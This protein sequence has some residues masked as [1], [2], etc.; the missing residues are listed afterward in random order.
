VKILSGAVF[1]VICTLMV[2]GWQQLP[3]EYEPIE[4]RSVIM[5]QIQATEGTNYYAMS[6]YANQITEVLYPIVES[7]LA[8]S[9]MVMVPGFGSGEGAVNR[10]FAILEFIEVRQRDKS[11]KNLVDE[12]REKAAQVP[13]ARIQPF[14]PAGIGSRGSPVQFVIGGPDYDELVQW[15]D[16]IIAKCH[17]FPGLTDVRYDYQETTPQLHVD[18]D[19]ERANELGV[20]TA[21]V[22]AA[23][24][25]ML[26]SKQV[27]T[28]VER[29]QEYD[30]VLQA[31]RLSRATP[32]NLSNIY[33]R[34][35]TSGALIPLDS[36]VKVVEHGAAGEL[37]RY[38]R[39]RAITISGNV[40]PGYA[41]SDALTFL[42]TTADQELPEYKQIF[43]KGQ[44]KDMVSSAGSLILIF[45][46]A[47]TISYLALA[48]Q[49]E[50]FVCPFIVM[51]TVPLGMVGAI[52]ALNIM[53]L[54]INI[55]VQIGIIMLIGLA[56][57]NGILIVEFANQMR[58]AGH[59][60]E[61]AL[62]LAAKLRLRPVLMTGIST[63]AG[64]LP[65]LFASGAGAASRG[66]LGAVVV[67]GG[68]SSCLLT[69]FIVPVAYLVF[70]KWSGSPKELQ[71]KVDALELA[72]PVAID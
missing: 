72:H 61:E 34:S 35:T 46:L 65:L 25:T 57:K 64:A 7:G 48:A 36:V 53:G 54:T 2:V 51:L 11:T 6:A 41:L 15:R 17:A 69:L 38:N 22:G 23:L 55:Y 16:L 33:V 28:F 58:D 47:L 18:I 44:S 43:Y 71:H 4:D 29:G 49:F 42:R 27:T 66:C 8:K 19:R 62:F 39:V 26:G 20:P 52:S 13:G 40:A 5:M 60:F 50:S 21:S 30:V 12:V 59:P 56:A 70:A 37:S 63:V 31:D 67:F 32:T 9:L 68:L 3:S 1:A 45:A 24:E 10:G 14:L